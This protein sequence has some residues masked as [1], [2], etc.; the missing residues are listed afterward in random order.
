MPSIT[1]DGVTYDLPLDE[2]QAQ[3]VTP[4]NEAIQALANHAS[5]Y[6]ESVRA[7]LFEGLVSYWRLG[8]VSGS[9]SDAVGSN[10]LAD[11]NT[12]T[13]ADGKLGK[14][15]QFTAA[16]SEYLSIADNA[17]LSTGDIDFTFCAWVYADSLAADRIIIGKTNLSTLGEY[18]LAF[19]N[20]SGRFRFAIQNAGTFVTVDATILG[21]PST[22]TWYFIVGWHDSV[23]NTVNIQVNNGTADSGTTG[24]TVP[25]DSAQPFHIGADSTPTTFWNGRVD[26]V[27]FWKRVLTA[28][29]KTALYNGGLGRAYPF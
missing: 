25:A 29:E 28:A 1:V 22:A 21:A 2:Y 15:A 13:Q 26:A 6:T 24:A 7:G 19:S 11:N 9:R 23:A 18:F 10:T 4:Y 14:A 27:G 5:S 8:E 12:V 17:S 20:S 3:K 16:N